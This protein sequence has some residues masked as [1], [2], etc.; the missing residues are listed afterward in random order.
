MILLSRESELYSLWLDKV[1]D[2]TLEDELKSISGDAD[3][4]QDRFYKDLEFGT[5]G[6]RGVIGAGTNR[7]NIYT[8]GR[9]TQGFADYIN[10]TTENASVAIAYDSRINSDLF[11]E[12]A[13]RIFAANG[14]KVWLYPE[15][16][17]T[18][19]LSFAVRHYGCAGGVVV[20]ASH[21]PSKYNGYKAY[22]PDGCQLSGEASEAV[23]AAVEKVDMFSGIKSVDFDEALKNGSIE[24]IGNDT[25]EEYYKNVLAQRV[26]PGIA[27]KSGLKVIYTPL[28]GTGNKP[29]RT[30]LDRIGIK[31]VTIVKEQELPDGN[32]PTAPYPNPEIR[33]PFECALKLADEIKP[34]LLLAT[35][36]DA[37]RVGI[38][39]PEGDHYRLMTGNEVGAMLMEYI[40]SQRTANGTLPK[41]PVSVKTIVTTSICE[42]IAAKYGCELRNVLTGFKYIGGQIAELEAEGHAERYVFGFE[43]S[44]GYLCG[45]YV[46]DKDAVVASMLIC[47][48]AAYYRTIGK[49]LVDVMNE[50]YAEYGL[51]LHKT[52]SFTFEGASGMKKMA[53]IMESLH[54]SHKTSIAGYKVIS[55]SDYKESVKTV[56]ATGEKTE[57]TLPKSDV[58]GYELEDGNGV[59]VRPSGTE[60]KI[61]VYVTAV[62]RNTDEATAIKDKLVADM[63]M[64]FK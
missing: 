1:T 12:T 61:K 22:G 42:K 28:H 39:V 64:L 6:L 4:I 33:Q 9:A 53:E 60:P 58:I 20:T 51:Y 35:D 34:D 36:P 25:Y 5:A 21:N 63:E 57:I 49:S 27:E 43:E 11:S 8:V 16:A 56:I 45:G 10:S 31:D 52:E 24:Y 19:M 18:P 17:P 54:S 14:I 37:D 55:V 13:A 15:L 59:I 46:R 50:I 44:Y 40:L 48:M 32:F 30:I 7:M 29:V 62:A 2:K 41:N 38:A 3:A 47:E 23:T 26:N